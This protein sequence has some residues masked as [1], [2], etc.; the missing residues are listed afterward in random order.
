MPDS[1]LT[2]A[3]KEAYASV[4][5]STVIYDTLQIAHD[6]VAQD[7]F[8][9][10]ALKDLDATLE[11]DTVATTFTAVPFEF[12]LPQKDGQGVPELQIIVGNIGRE[13][14]D[15]IASVKDS[16]KPV[17]VYYRPFL[18]TDLT[19]P[20]M[21]PPLQFSVKEVTIDPFQ[22]QFRATFF[23]FKNMRWPQQTYNRVRFPT[24]GE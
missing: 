5:T 11:G 16:A 1:T 24:L 6:D 3:L 18:S 9:V 23:D 14:S 10:K 8:F 2:D 17:T 12:R 4:P 13:A 20:Q 7:L 19:Q 21:D 22:V 15:Y